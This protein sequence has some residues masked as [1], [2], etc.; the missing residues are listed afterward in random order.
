MQNF[1]D[2]DEIKQ[3]LKI[4][5]GHKHQDLWKLALYTGM[6]AGEISGLRWECVKMDHRFGGHQGLILVKAMYDSKT[7][8]IQEYTKNKD[9]RVIP[10]LPECRPVLERFRA[11]YSGSYVLGGDQPKDCSHFAR[12]IKALYEKHPGLKRIK[13]HG[14]RH[15][16]CSYLESTGMSRRIVSG[17]MGHMDIKTTNRYSHVSDPM[18]GTEVTRWLSSRD[19]QNSNKEI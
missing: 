11:K 18:L 16:F 13:F 4:S 12:P 15:T 2:A 9:I 7:G 3:F 10:I 8:K 6:R 19:Q 17:I 5:N 14:L 1:L